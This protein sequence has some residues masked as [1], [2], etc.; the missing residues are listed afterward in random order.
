MLAAA[1]MIP[2]NHRSL[3]ASFWARI[4]KLS[5]LAR[6]AFT[7]LVVFVVIGFAL[8]RTI[9]D[10]TRQSALNAAKTAAFA[11]FQVLRNHLTPA[12]LQG[13]LTGQAFTVFDHLVRHDVLNDR[14]KVVKVWNPEGVVVYSTDRSIIGKRFP[15][16][17]DVQTALEG[18]PFADV[19]NLE[20]AED[21]DDRGFGRLLQVYIPI[22]FGTGLPVGAFEIYET[23]GPLADQISQLQE[24]TSM[25]LAAGLL[26]LY[27]VLFGV[28]RAGSRTITSQQRELRQKAVD[29]EQSYSDIISALAAAV[30]ARDSQTEMH[31]ER[32]ARLAL[33]LGEY[34]GLDESGRRGLRIGAQLHDIGKIGIPDAILR[35]PG[36]L[37]TEEWQAMRRHPVIGFEMI[38]NVAS[39]GEALPVVRCHHERWDGAGFPDGLAGE[40]IPLA[41][42][43]F[44][45]VDTFDAIT[46]DRPY[47]QGAT[48]ADALAVIEEE[49]GRQF[50][51]ILAIG[52][53]AMMSNARREQAAD[54]RAALRAAA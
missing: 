20:A 17:D 12:D 5:L 8:S 47:R 1:K 32:V 23:Y 36:P 4:G 19:S 34:V 39:L 30:D 52:F 9:G 13:A 27:L 15:L 31:S 49:A 43:V 21:Q 7:S 28:V 10:A 50:D 54:M 11:N 53:V 2:M 24:Q 51:P 40:N 41:A 35:K 45:I 3:G 6:F 42:R 14:I 22:R 18:K 46:S 37:S 29:L 16:E 25:L 44:A 48:V 26:V 38:R 33:R